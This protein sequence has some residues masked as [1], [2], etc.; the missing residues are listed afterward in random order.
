MAARPSRRKPIVATFTCPVCGSDVRVDASSCKE[1]GS[2]AQTGWSEDSLY[3][4]LDLPIAGDE[5]WAEESSFRERAARKDTWRWLLFALLVLALL[6][7]PTC[8]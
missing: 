1:C 5:A 3:D 8:F 2:D 4:D 6:G 7:L